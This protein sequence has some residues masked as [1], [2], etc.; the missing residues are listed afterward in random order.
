[1][2]RSFLVLSVLALLTVGLCVGSSAAQFKVA[3]ILPS[4]INDGEWSQG[5]YDSLTELVAEYG[6][7]NFAFAYSENMWN[8]AD[9]GVAMRD[10][11]AEGYNL[12]IAHGGQYGNSLMEV[13]ADYRNTS[14]AIG[15]DGAPFV[16]LGAPNVFGYDASA[17]QVGYVV[18]ELAGKLSQSGVIGLVNPIDSGDVAAYEDGFIA[19]A[20]AARPD[21]TV[22]SVWTGSYS[23]SAL[24][25]EAAQTMV[26]AGADI[27]TGTSQA[28]VSAM[29]VARAN[30]ALWFGMRI[31]Q[32]YLAPDTV[33]L[34]C[35]YDWKVF[36]RP[37]IAAIK[38]GV[39]G[40]QL[41]D[42]NLANGGLYIVMNPPALFRSTIGGIVNGTISTG[43]Q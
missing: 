30:G 39:K 7:A 34:S 14:F 8:V 41:M 23:D 4:A 27:L 5:L 26:A 2:K 6:A 37:M 17:D 35:V 28:V 43:H 32:S 42:L 10:Y 16:A 19:G 21:I 1:M 15:T 11:A 40:G 33:A 24:A 12:I 20:K 22:L 13:A 18:G 36:L 31:D 9:A 3:V 38:S 29:D 25:S